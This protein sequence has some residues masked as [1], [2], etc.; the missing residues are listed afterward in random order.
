M[1]KLVLAA[2]VA[3]AAITTT[4][5]F[6]LANPASALCDHYR[7]ELIRV[8]DDYGNEYT[9]CA[10]PDGHIIEEWTFYRMQRDQQPIYVYPR[11]DDEEFHG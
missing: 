10:L 3:L 9:L 7:G 11:S 4:P 1:A 8:V 6:A 5:A 2:A